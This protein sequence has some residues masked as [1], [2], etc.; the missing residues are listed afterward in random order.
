MRK[1]IKKIASFSPFG[2]W[3]AYAVLIACTIGSLFI[4]CSKDD[5]GGDKNSD[6]TTSDLLEVKQGKIVYD[7]PNSKT[8]TVWFDNYGKQW[9]EE[10]DGNMY[11]LDD[12][13]GK[14]WQADMNMK[15]YRER[16]LWFVQAYFSRYIFNSDDVEFFLDEGYTTGT[17]TIAGKSCTV[18]ADAS[19]KKL[20]FWKKLLFLDAIAVNGEVRQKAI[21]FSEIAPPEGTFLPPA[22][23]TK[24]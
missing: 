10:F 21:S 6:P 19:N 20:G 5:G 13:A 1:F 11:I 14:A 9:R 7:A 24:E 22:D 12:T 17:E 2:G 16:E 15:T 4:G 3:G 23:Y 8:I 18:Y